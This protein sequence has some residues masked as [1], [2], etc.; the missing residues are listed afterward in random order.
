[1]SHSEMFDEF[2][3]L[4]LERGLISQAELEEEDKKPEKKKDLS[5]YEMLYGVSE[6]SGRDIIEE[7]HPDTVVLMRSHDK[8]NGIF[9]NIQE[10]SDIMNGLI[11]EFPS[12]N[13]FGQIY[14]KAKNELLNEVIKTAFILDR[15]NEQELMVLADNCGEKITKFALVWFAWAGIAAASALLTYVGLTGKYPMAQGM[16]ADT[17]KAIEGMVHR[18][19]K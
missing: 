2:L 18:R 5:L 19:R 14:S 12:G 3:G 13:Q 9:E 17:E 11:R 7:A 1:M 15:E 8:L 10:R 6:K 4:A 16:R